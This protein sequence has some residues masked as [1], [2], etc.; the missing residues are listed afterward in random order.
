MF[1]I[2]SDFYGRWTGGNLFVGTEYWKS[3]SNNPLVE[4]R[5][6]K[7]A[8][9]K[10]TLSCNKCNHSH[11]NKPAC[12]DDHL[13]VKNKVCKVTFRLALLFKGQDTEYTTVKWPIEDYYELM[14]VRIKDRADTAQN[15]ISPILC[16]LVGPGTIHMKS[17]F[18]WPKYCFVSKKFD[19]N[20]KRYFSS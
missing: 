12:E 1:Q 5:T 7:E 19:F 2:E 9:I 3:T 4:R 20:C 10:L 17:R 6:R 14:S 15:L 18:I 16:T 13:H 11:A 8:R